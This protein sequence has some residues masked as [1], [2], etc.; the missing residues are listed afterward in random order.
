MSATPDLLYSDVEDQLRSTLRSVLKGRSDAAAMLQRIESDQPY[1]LDLWRALATEVG[2][3]ALPIP[4]AFGGAGAS[5]RETAV[6]AEEMGRAVAPVPYL[7]SAVLATRLLMG[8]DQNELLE[9]LA[10]G[11]V[12]ATAATPL[13]TRPGTPF[14]ARVVASGGSVSGTVTSVA[15][16]LVADRFV[17]PAREGDG[18]AVFIV[19]A[20]DASVEPAVSMDLT[21]PLSTVSF[22]GAAASRVATGQQAR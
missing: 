9:Q 10:S 13:A 14:E 5:W 15:D 16:A 1:D 7:G 11:T 18:A 21:R 12:T 6:V 17:V 8:C 20:A 4:E 22:D 3:A 19:D 2:A